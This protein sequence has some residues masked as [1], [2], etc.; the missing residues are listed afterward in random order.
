M[1]DRGGKK[2][3]ISL[4]KINVLIDPTE[5]ITT[6]LTK[7]KKTSG[8]KIEKNDVSFL[9]KEA[10]KGKNGW[11]GAMKKH[12]TNFARWLLDQAVPG[13]SAT[14]Y[15]QTCCASGSKIHEIPA[16]SLLFFR[17]LKK[18]IST[19]FLLILFDKSAATLLS[20]QYLSLFPLKRIKL[21]LY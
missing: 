17:T 21:S 11:N 13:Y 12:S 15:G 3:Q 20:M 6:R 9:L 19:N 16:M 4:N 7:F 2:S 8:S 5:I 10:K 18:V 14:E 1:L